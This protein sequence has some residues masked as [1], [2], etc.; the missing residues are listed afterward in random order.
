MKPAYIPETWSDLLNVRKPSLAV[1]ITFGISAA[2]NLYLACFTGQFWFWL[3][4]AVCFLVFA[5]ELRQWL[6]HRQEGQRLV[7]RNYTDLDYQALG[8][9]PSRKKERTR[10]QNVV[11]VCI[12]I[13]V[14]VL[15][16]Y[17]RTS[18]YTEIATAVWGATMPVAMIV[19]GYNEV[20]Y[21]WREIGGQ[22]LRLTVYG[23]SVLLFLYQILAIP[24]LISLPKL[25]PAHMDDLR[26]YMEAAL[27]L[28]FIPLLL[29]NIGIVVRDSWQRMDEKPL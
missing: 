22:W 29:L 2:A 10:S 21:T 25:V 24:R 1:D 16:L 6:R 14:C 20:R 9:I 19:M 17:L 15:G 12:S 5:L 11:S 3:L 7:T 4:F 28:A 8:I 23:L 26:F 27:A 18:E 13:A